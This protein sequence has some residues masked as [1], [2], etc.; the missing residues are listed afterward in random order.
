MV[1]GGG[2][3]QVVLE[4]GSEAVV[5]RNG[6]KVEFNASGG[7][8]VYG[9][10]PVVLHPAANDT[11][12]KLKAPLQIGDPD[13]GG[14][15]V[16]LSASDGKPLHAALADLPEY[17]T[18]DE[19]LAAAEQLKS[20]HPAAHVPTPK[21]L[22]KNLFANRNTGRM[23]GTF[24]TIRSGHDSIYLSSV[25]YDN[26]NARVQW[27]DDGHQSYGSKYARLPVRLVW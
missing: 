22:D 8:D 2:K 23:A 11:A 5:V 15:Y 7:I 18:F 25:P 3:V 21:E 1:S 17:K 19:A 20:V 10:I 13:D 14:V 24:N 12:A 26:D 27:F 9:N 6:I 4:E 16:G